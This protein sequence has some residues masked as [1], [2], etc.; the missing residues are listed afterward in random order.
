MP[1]NA[2]GTKAHG[3]NEHLGVRELG[4]ALKH[5]GPLFSVSSEIRDERVTYPVTTTWLVL[6]CSHDRR[7]MEIPAGLCWPQVILVHFF[8][9]QGKLDALWVLLRKGYDRVSVMR[10]QPG[11]TVGFSNGVCPQHSHFL[12]PCLCGARVTPS[13][14]IQLLCHAV[15]NKIL[16]FKILGF[17]EH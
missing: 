9:F 11:D 10:P 2:A 14:Q 8:L 4:A 1:R 15:T 16:A 13:E 3:I 7:S 17:A 6:R 12:P 5:Q